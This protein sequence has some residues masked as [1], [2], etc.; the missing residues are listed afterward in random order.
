MPAWR[1]YGWRAA[2]D[3]GRAA[4][5]HAAFR[6]ALAAVGAEVVVGDTAVPGDPDAI[7]AYDPTLPTDRGVITAS[8]RQAWSAR[9]T[10][11]GRRPTSPRRGPRA[12]S[13]RSTASGNRRGWRHVLARPRARCWS[14]AATARTTKASRRSERSSVM[15]V[16]A[17][18]LRPPAPPRGL[19]ACLHLMSFIS[20]LDHDLAVVYLPMMPVRLVELLRERGIGPRRGARRRVRHAG[21]ERA[22]ARAA[23]GAGRST[24]TPR[25]RRRMEAA[26]VDVRTFAGPEI[27]RKGD[28]GPTCLTRPLD[29]D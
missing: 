3:P 22:R 1:D 9:R 13:A 7:Y 12:C 10:G 18:R 6:E 28:G 11:G 8:P 15:S 2:P 4:E 29:R 25:P 20:P 14:D 23:C 19:T 16:D 27:S 17:D 5:E 26:G 24:A 21:P